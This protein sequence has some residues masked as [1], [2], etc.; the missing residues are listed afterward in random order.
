[1]VR[2]PDLGK[3]PL[4]AEE[5]EANVPQDLPTGGRRNRSL[6]RMP[7]LSHGDVLPRME[8]CEPTNETPIPAV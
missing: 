6:G 8:E 1:M 7:P 3:R 4:S 5:E 2:N